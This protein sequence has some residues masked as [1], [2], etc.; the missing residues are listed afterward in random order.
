MSGGSYVSFLAWKGKV[1]NQRAVAIATSWHECSIDG[2][3][4][5]FS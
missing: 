5:R 4:W 1:A 3:T 2:V